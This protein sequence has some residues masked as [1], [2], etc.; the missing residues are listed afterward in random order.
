MTVMQAPDQ[1]EA[2]VP[3][4]L[5]AEGFRLRQSLEDVHEDLLLTVLELEDEWLLDDRIAFSLRHSQ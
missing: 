5:D 3:R 2:L 4:A 1:F